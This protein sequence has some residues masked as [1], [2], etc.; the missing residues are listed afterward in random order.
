MR[1]IGSARTLSAAPAVPARLPPP[2]PTTSSRRTRCAASCSRARASTSRRAS[3]CCCSWPYRGAAA[4]WSRSAARRRAAWRGAARPQLTWRAAHPRAA[5]AAA[6]ARVAAPA[7]AVAAEA[8]AAR[9]AAQLQRRRLC[10]SRAAHLRALATRRPRRRR[11]RLASGC[12]C[13]SWA[14]SARCTTTRPC[15]RPR[16]VPGPQQA[17]A[18]TRAAARHGPAKRRIGPL[19]LPAS[20]GST[21]WRGRSTG[22]SVEPEMVYQTTAPRCCVAAAASRARLGWALVG[23]PSSC[24]GERPARSRARRPPSPGLCARRLTH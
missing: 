18:C 20:T 5:A 21:T 16:C 13:T 6:A 9:A 22:C 14:P 4:A 10:P 8:A 11:P 7:A 1:W 17:S 19:T 3:T 23:P 15:A 24:G 12:A 2:P